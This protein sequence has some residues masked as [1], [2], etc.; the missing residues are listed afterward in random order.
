MSRY[1]MASACFRLPRQ[2]WRRFLLS[3][4][5]CSFCCL[6]IGVG[7]IFR[8]SEWKRW[9]TTR[10]YEY[11][12]EA[13]WSVWDIFRRPE[14][15][16]SLKFPQAMWKIKNPRKVSISPP[17]SFLW[18]SWLMSFL[19]RRCVYPFSHGKLAPLA[20]DGWRHAIRWIDAFEW[21]KIAQCIITRH[22]Q[23]HC[24]R[25]GPIKHK[26]AERYKHLHFFKL[27]NMHRTRI[28][29]GRGS[30]STHHG[31]KR[32]LKHTTPDLVTYIQKVH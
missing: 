5:L 21:L 18:N 3:Q 7:I 4:D 1:W 11:L 20:D 32:I 9:A 23:C 17:C 27:A 26:V 29:M 31:Q 6:Y 30:V 16:Y 22:N 24:C 19:V 2:G 12:R 10:K 13:R 28:V 25:L 15:K 14:Y 8:K